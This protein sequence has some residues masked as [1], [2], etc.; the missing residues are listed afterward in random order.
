MKPL[1]LKFFIVAGI[2]FLGGGG[3]IW[4]Q[5]FV[6][7]FLASHDGFSNW[8]FVKEWREH[9][10]VF[11]EVKEIVIQTDEAFARVVEQGQGA[12]VGIQSK[13]GSLVLSG[14]GFV[15][16]S[17]GFVLTV[18]EVVP[19]GYSVLVY[20][21]E[22]KDPVEAEVLKRDMQANIALLKISERS[23]Q[24]KSFGELKADDLGSSLVMVA[25]VVEESE[26]VGIVNHGIMRSADENV[27]RTSFFDKQTV[28]GSPLFTIEGEIVGMTTVAP[29]GRILGIPSSTLREFSGL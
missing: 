7:P 8:S 13:S 14:S 6:L 28:R 12:V 17:D 15:V 29:D 5:A 1:F 11:T 2:F 21:E 23:L 3:G 25:R 19:Q 22:G 4:A 26:L 18:A 9:T 24:T 27:I 20:F 16:A 10:T